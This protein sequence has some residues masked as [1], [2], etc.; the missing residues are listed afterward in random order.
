MPNTAAALQQPQPISLQV[1][2]TPQAWAQFATTLNNW[3]QYLAAQNTGYNPTFKTGYVMVGGPNG[4]IEGNINFEFGTN[5]PNPSGTNGAGL[6]LGS[7]AGGGIANPF[8]I[9]T[10]QAYDLTTPGNQL[11]ITA[12]ETQPNSTQ[13]GGLLWLIGGGADLGTGGELL[14]QGGTSARQNGGSA[15]LAG[16]N[17]TT[18]GIPGDAYV[19]GGSGLAPAQGANVHLIMTEVA[20][21]SGNIRFRVN[22]TILY[23]FDQFGA[24]FIG[25]AGCGTAGQTLHSGGPGASCYWG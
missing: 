12:G 1:P 2:T 22:S 10:D 5:L 18:G 21:I 24:I 8:W 9:I 11:G 19:I 4:Q 20:G 13:A 6:L 7:G 17:A 25:T 23:Q 14:L 3:L 16:G 15:I